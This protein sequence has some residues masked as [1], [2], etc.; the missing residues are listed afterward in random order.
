MNPELKKKWIDALRSG[1]YTKGIGRLC[2]IKNGV[3]RHCCLGVLYELDYGP[4]RWEPAC[5]PDGYLATHNGD[6]SF[7]GADI[8]GDGDMH[9]LALINDDNDSFEPVVAF[10]EKNL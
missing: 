9:Q 8:L 5:G 2:S 1:N 4:G 3:K 6:S 7:Y 10:I